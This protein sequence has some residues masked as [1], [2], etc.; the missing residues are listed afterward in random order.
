M[1]PLLSEHILCQVDAHVLQQLPLKCVCALAGLS[2]RL[3][4]S[5]ATPQLCTVLGAKQFDQG[6]VLELSVCLCRCNTVLERDVGGF[7]VEASGIAIKHG[8]THL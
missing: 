5:I 3:E 2:R 8:L 4:L 7:C 1:Y 6:A